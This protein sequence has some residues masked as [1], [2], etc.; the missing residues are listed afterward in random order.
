MTDLIAVE[1]FR[2]SI[3]RIAVLTFGLIVLGSGVRAT[4]SGLA[5]PDWPLCYE[6]LIPTFDFQVF[7]E[8][9]HRL[10]ALILGIMVF[11]SLVTLLRR[12]VLRRQFAK[13][14]T[15][16]CILF[17]VQ[18]VLGGLTVL[19]LLD[20]KTVAAHLINAC[21]FYGILLWIVDSA[22]R[23]IMK[24]MTFA[25][26]KMV[27]ALIYSVTF[28]IFVQIAVGGTVSSNY[29]GLVCPD[30]PTCHG[31][32]VPPA[33]FLIWIQMT[34]RFIGL[35][36]LALAILLAFATSRLPLPRRV[37]KSCRILPSLIMVQIALGLVNIFWSLPT[38]A[39]V[40]HMATALLCLTLMLYAS[41]SVS[42]LG[43]SFVGD[44][45]SQPR[46]LRGQLTKEVGSSL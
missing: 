37:G 43:A 2:R 14:L 28:L 36:I 23:Y 40:M 35:T 20:P 31:Q 38:W 24:P 25:I 21:L 44:N 1:K 7:I 46:K 17:L 41:L 34:H 5:C 10:I 42:Y 32:W 30:F 18:V 8:W 26:P 11:S 15:F 22:R 4:Q 16:A 29:A 3:G 27:K 6:Q 39:S 33:N 45:T 19:K 13:P 12:P 9:F